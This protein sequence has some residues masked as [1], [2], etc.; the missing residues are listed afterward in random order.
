MRLIVSGVVFIWSTLSLWPWRDTPFEMFI[1]KRATS[2]KAEFQGILVKAHDKV[3]KKEAPTLF[4]ALKQIGDEQHVDYAKYFRDINIADIKN[5][6]K[7]NLVLL[8]E[9]LKEPQSKL[10]QGLDLKGGVSFTLQIDPHVL[11]NKEAEKQAKLTKAIDIMDRRINGLGVAEPIIRAK[12]DN[13][14]EIQLPGVSTQDNPEVVYALKKPAKLEFR[15]VHPDRRLRPGMI[16]ES[17]H[18]LGYEPMMLAHEDSRSGEV[19]E[20]AFFVKRIPELT[21][22]AVKAAYPVMNN[23]GGYEI[24]ITLTDA[25]AKR[26]ATLTKENIGRQLAI[27]L[28]G[29]LYSAPVIKSEIPNGHASISGDFSPRDA[30]ELANVLNNPLEFELQLAEMYEMGPSLANEAR[31]S[32]VLAS[33]IGAGA[34][35][36]FMIA[37]YGIPGIVAVISVLFNVLIVM[38]VMASIGATLTLPG[39]AAL[40]LTIGMG[41]D[42][43]ILIFERMRE[44]LRLSKG[45]EAALLAGHERALATIVDANLTTLLT[46]VILILFGT[47][48]IKG[49]GVT[50]SIGILATMFCALVTSRGMLELLIEKKWIKKI[51][52]YSFFKNTKIDFFKYWK[53]AMIGSLALVVL[54]I[55]ALGVRGNK[56]YGIDFLGGEEVSVNFEHKPS[57]EQIAKIVSAKHLGEVAPVFKK[58][59]GGEKETLVLQTEEGRG[60][61]VFETLQRSMPESKLTWVGMN[62]VGAAV[63]KE[64][65]A[66]AFWAIILS[67]LGI[68]LYVAVR[69]EMG[70]G[71]GALISTAHDILMTIGIYVL[72]GKQFT[73]P[74]VAA[75]LM[76]VGYSINDTIVVFDRIR[77]ELKLEPKLSLKDV[78]NLAI[79]CTLSRT[80]LTSFATLLASFSLYLF[81]GGVINDFALVFTIGIV[82]GTFSSIFIASPIFFWWHKGDRKHVEKHEILP[83]YEWDASR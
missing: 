31:T 11:G 18:P 37:Y 4:M 1:A 75:I 76:I 41:V 2:Q 43:N 65:R 74:M 54:G 12:G 3:A 63:T 70:Y 83:K 17:E 16:K 42:S 64:I 67:L 66:N 36:I 57:V 23:Y 35:I 56:I 39:I 34:V 52:T 53:P 62:S 78:V 27:V 19:Y 72:L 60:K 7:R 6:Q 15:W 9:L 47:G 68:M 71:I 79:N 22:D 26:F 5:G 81:A 82:T 80:I 55:I 14:I 49:F 59:L 25:G 38:G 58:Q 46:A 50:L 13:Q 28:D 40:V 32:S 10:K 8:N 61:Q 48:P 24:S 44:E 69:F 33:V 45:L 73:A 51:F 29:Q 77:E 20:S 21:G 30:I